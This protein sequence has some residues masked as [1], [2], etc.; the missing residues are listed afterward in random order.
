MADNT[1]DDY[2]FFEEE[3]ITIVGTAETSQQMAV[4]GKDEIEKHNAADLAVLLSDALNLGFT[5]YG[6]YGNMT[7]INLRGFDS[8]RI[9]ILINGM[10]VN[11]IL[12]GKINI[13]QIDLDYVERIEVIYGG[14]DTKYNVSGA[15]GGVINIITVKKQETGL[16]LG[17]SV[18]NTS[19]MPG[20]YRDRNG[21]KQGPHLQD[22]ADTQ[23]YTLNAAYGRKKISISAGA[24]ANRAENHYIFKDYLNKTRRKDNNE[25]RD[26]GADISAVMDF[27][28][29]VKMIVSSNFYYGKKN[30][31]SSSF[32][33]FFDKQRDINTRHSL[34]FDMPRIFADTLAAEV[35]LAYTFSNRFYES[36]AN[37]ISLHDQHSAMAVNRWNWY[38]GERLTLR[39]GFD[40][41]YI[42]LDSTEIGERS[43]HDS[44]I[45]LTAEYKPLEKFIIIPSIKAAL[46]SGGQGGLR[47]VPKLGL[48]WNI[49][50]SFTLKNNYFR[51]FKFPDFE[52]LYWQGSGGFGNPD[53]KPEDGWGADLGA[54]WQFKELFNL[55]TVFFTQWIQDSIH[56]YP[57]NSGVWRPEN[58]GEAIFFGLDSKLCFEIPVSIGQIKKIIPSVSYQYLLNYLLSFGYDFSSNKRIPYMPSHTI[59]ASLEIPWNTGSLLIS[60]HYESMRYVDRENITSLDP[61]FLLNAV[62]NQKLGKSFTIFAALRNI[63]NESY[64]SFYDYSMPGITF[65]MGLRMKIEVKNEKNNN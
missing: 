9:A 40:Y 59:G 53:L 3:G 57:K 25:V 14:S 32:S 41:R 50:D 43:R 20:E 48:L 1:D 23:N 12:D 34:M 45:Y 21:Q 31:P 37:V 61:H 10:P 29:A 7:S 44:G 28:S 35:S 54:A 11:S 51:S 13:E 63:L 46:S 56:W 60:A 19:V 4:I 47:P 27:P 15:L 2:L 58:V 16:K 33:E 26:T 5:R 22:L 38:P 64:E 49:N 39:S 65:T 52:E 6:G 55:G 30:I 17:A 62:L 8:K 18:S 36:P 42:F 24:F